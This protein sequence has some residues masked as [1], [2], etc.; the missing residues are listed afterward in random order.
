MCSPNVPVKP[1]TARL[2]QAWDTLADLMTFPNSVKSL[3]P[4]P[5]I[6]RQRSEIA[7]VNYKEVSWLCRHPTE[8]LDSYW[9]A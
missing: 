7:D 3:W 8:V 5:L 9:P 6:P 2:S 4:T 1:A